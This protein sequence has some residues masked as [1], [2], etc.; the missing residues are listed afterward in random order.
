MRGSQALGKC[1]V[2]VVLALGSVN[3]PPSA[4]AVA[5]EVV[6]PL[7][8]KIIGTPV[9]RTPFVY[10]VPAFEVSVSHSC[11]A[12]K[13]ACVCR[14]GFAIPRVNI[15]RPLKLSWVSTRI[16]FSDRPGFKMWPSIFNSI[17]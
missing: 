7:S 15:L 16:G 13:N 9:R 17:I 10:R 2:F 3:V 6:E 5:M 1:L 11:F 8:D 14:S 12:R 4:L